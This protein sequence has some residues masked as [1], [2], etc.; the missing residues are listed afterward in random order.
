[1]LALPAD[2]TELLRFEN[3]GT[4]SSREGKRLELKEDFNPIDLSDYTRFSP[5]SPTR[6][7]VSSSSV[8]ATSLA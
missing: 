2:L 3:D 4:V 5:L 7:A 8:S 6:A 1:M